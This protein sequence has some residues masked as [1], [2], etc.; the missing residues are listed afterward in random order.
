MITEM[1]TNDDN[2]ARKESLLKKQGF[3]NNI[4]METIPQVMDSK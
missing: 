3:K 4:P 2:E 1:I